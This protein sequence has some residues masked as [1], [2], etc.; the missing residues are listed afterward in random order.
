MQFLERVFQKLLLN[1]TWWVNRK[2]VDGKNIF[3]GGF[4]GLDNI[5]VFDRSAELPTG[6][7]IDQSDGTSWMAMYSLNMLTIALELAKTNPVYED[8]ATKF[9]EHY[10]Y[11][12]D[13]INHI[14]DMGVSLWDE[15][16]GFYYDV[17]RLPDDKEI[18]LKVRSMVGLISLFAIDTLEPETLAMLPTFKKRM[19]WFINNRPDLRKNVA[20]MEKKGVGAHRLLA[21]VWEEKL[22]RI[23]HKMLDETEFLSDYGI[24]ALSK[25]P[26][27][28]T[29]YLP[30]Q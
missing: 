14:G 9:Y 18:Q 2:D 19:D 23:L 26:R 29:L 6:G 17:L 5:G 10:L 28:R 20:C 24:R 25:D 30:S 16:D 11:I 22:K 3:Q 27:R 15:E 12:A 21:I 13:A 8:I 7:Y 4:L 1:F